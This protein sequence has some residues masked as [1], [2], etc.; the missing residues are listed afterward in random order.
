MSFYLYEE[1]NMFSSYFLFFGLSF[2]EKIP[3]LA[4]QRLNGS[5]LPRILIL[6]IFFLAYVFAYSLHF[7]LPKKFILESYIFAPIYLCF[8]L[9][10]SSNLV[11]IHF[12]NQYI[13]KRHYSL[14]KPP[15]S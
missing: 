2:A 1:A 7:G 10:K 15:T 3:Q 4:L 5:T 14:T 6:F 9:C 12:E 13:N 8:P 11:L